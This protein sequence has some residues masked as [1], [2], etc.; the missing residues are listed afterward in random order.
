MRLHSASKDTARKSVTLDYFEKRRKDEER[1]EKALFKN[2]K[3]LARAARLDSRFGPCTFQLAVPSRA[4]DE[5][6][7]GALGDALPRLEAEYPLLG[8]SDYRTGQAIEEGFFWPIEL[9]PRFDGAAAGIGLPIVGAFCATAGAE[10]VRVLPAA[11]LKN[12][13]A[14]HPRLRQLLTLFI[15]VEQQQWEMAQITM[16]YSFRYRL[17]S[18]VWDRRAHRHQLAYAICLRCG[19]LLARSREPPTS[20]PL[21][22]AC[23]K[24]SPAA[25]EWPTHA[26]A[27][28]ERG[29]WWLRC[30]YAGC[31]TPPFV[32][33]RQRRKCD[34]HDTSNLTAS[35]RAG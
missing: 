18:W 8:L 25:R 20:H 15:L 17:M 31:T 2:P 13:A 7:L 3:G 32:A 22:S 14:E 1:L 16:P 26:V 29:T 27:P 23:A 24:E 28:A 6:A 30:D 21:C 5:L 10:L 33:K 11:H 4:A 35:K 34:Q 9:P 12:F 19:S